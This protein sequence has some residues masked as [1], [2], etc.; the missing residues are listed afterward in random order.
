M[1]GTITHA[2]FA[3]DVYN[4]LDKK[5]KLFLENNKEDIKTYAQG[6]DILFFYYSFNIKKSSNIRTYAKVFHK[7]KTKLFFYN[8]IEYIK[9][10]NLQYDPKIISFLYGYICHYK[11]DSIIHPYV[12]YKGGIFKKEN[13]ETYKYN[14]KH[15]DIES[16]I[17]AYMI[18][19]KENI[20][21][22][23]FKCYNF[24]FNNSKITQNLL[25]LINY[26][27]YKTYNINNIGKYYKKSIWIMKNLYKI[28]RY[29]PFMIKK[30][31]YK[32][33]DKLLPNNITKLY[34]ISYAYNLNNDNYY[35]NT[36]HKKWNHPRYKEEIY[37]LSVIDLYKKSLKETTELINNINQ[38]LYC[39]KNINYLNNFLL[40]ISFS[41]GKLCNDK[42][43]NK[44]FEY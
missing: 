31:S 6:H 34:P 37:N 41:S 28:C 4:K 14:S 25:D 16:Y 35:L 7:T 1:A 24:C 3:I 32:F 22:G 23:K 5:T 11:L 20:N 44:F 15:S 17:D 43:K 8:M 18:K 12:T 38:V 30:A 33:I 39:G 2:Y 29:D 42:T 19:Q 27:F 9:K 13:K 21:P 40:D 26:T 10:N 36:D